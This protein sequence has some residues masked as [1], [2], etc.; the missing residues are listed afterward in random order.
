M[1]KDELRNITRKVMKIS[2]SYHNLHMTGK[3]SNA[4]TKRT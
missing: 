1:K 2:V 3:V 4:E